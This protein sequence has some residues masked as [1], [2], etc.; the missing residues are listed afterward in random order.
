M[1]SMAS[2]PG[3]NRAAASLLVAVFAVTTV[4]LPSR[5]AFAE[6]TA[7][8]KETARSLMKEGRAKREAGDHK[9]ALEAFVGADGLMKLPTT[10]LEVARS[11]MDLGLLVE[12]RDTFLRVARIP[13]QP[14][15][16]APFDEAR[17]QAETFASD[18][19][20]RIPTI[21][22][23][24]SG[25]PEG[26]KIDVTIDGVA[27][28]AGV[29]KAP[30][31]VN[32]GKRIVVAVSGG[33]KRKHDIELIEGETKELAIDLTPS[34]EDEKPVEAP[35]PPP[36]PETP[37]PAE[38]P[39]GLGTVTWIGIGVAGAGILVG[40]ITGLMAMSKTSSAKERCEDTRCPPETHDELGSA[41]T[42]ATISTISFG[43]AAI[44]AGA[45]VFGLLTRG[46][47]E[48]A[49]KSAHIGP[50]REVRPLIGVGSIGIGGSF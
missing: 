25:V 41:R 14:N 3:R 17:K 29:L 23:S 50:L 49:P 7:A 24:F 20:T 1:G 37:K 11:Q 40:S 30:L 15:D 39:S 5:L 27:I 2:R 38:P 45:A 36:A 21:K 18:L 8:E 47:S 35:P 10:G 33:V 28:S 19:E 16:P 44:G 34:G 46:P 22:L 43:V 12:A 48:P 42:M 6:P 4:S 31:K 13:P 26:A 32:P 9:A